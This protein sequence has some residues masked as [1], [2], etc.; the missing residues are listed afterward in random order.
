MMS[1]EMA[2]NYKYQGQERQDELNLNWD[3]F[4]WRNYDYAIGR[5]MSVD[6]LAEEFPEWSPYSFTFN[7]P[8]RFVDPDGRA[9]DDIILRGKN[10]SSVTFVTDLVD[11]DVDASSLGV[12]FGG[13]YSFEGEDL[14][15]A[16][17]DI[18]G[19]FD[20]TGAADI[21][22]GSIEMKN[23][24][25]W[26]G[27]ASYAGVAVGVGDL[28]KTGKIPKH[29]KTIQKAIDGAK[30]SKNAK[31]LPALDS[32]GKVHGD[33]PSPG[34]LSKYSREDL[35][36]LKSDLEKSVQRRIEVTSKKGRDRGH[37]Q[38]QGAEQDLIK[39]IEKHLENN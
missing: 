9:P 4:K 11:I 6:P 12:D 37:G 3:S 1:P 16:A 19:I 5:F 15:V 27:V 13:N 10:G 7:N 26:S 18:A 2:Y 29:L 24:N 38:R 32:T 25:F 8:L 14:L 23:G 33:L 21:A 39:S 22:A 36:I 35:R 28:A 20:P 30:S 31:K 34:D 17:L